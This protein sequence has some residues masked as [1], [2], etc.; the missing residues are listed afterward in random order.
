MTR[1][2]VKKLL[3]TIMHV[4]PNFSTIDFANTV[5]A[6]TFLLHDYEYAEI[7]Q[8]LKYYDDMS[9]SNFAPT[10]AKLKEYARTLQ[11]LAV[12]DK[13]EAWNL[14]RDALKDSAY[15]SKERFEELP[16]LVKKAVGGASQLKDWATRGD[17]NESVVAS[18]F[19]RNYEAAV[20]RGKREAVL[21]HRS[22]DRL[23]ELRE[24]MYG[25]EHKAKPAEIE[26]KKLVKE[27]VTPEGADYAS[28]VREAIEKN[29][30]NKDVP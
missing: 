4:Y 27:Y 25:I 16:D 30:I 13:V 7:S 22:A 28:R 17:Y 6:W 9:G 21:D 29:G 23:E 10:P 8:A 19:Q 18:N 14:V 11:D 3:F 2:D 1:D 26:D 24:A 12:M 20:I 5:D 15:H